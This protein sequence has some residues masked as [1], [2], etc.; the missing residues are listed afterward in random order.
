MNPAQYLDALLTLPTLY[1]AQVSPDGRWAAWTWY[2][3]GPTA[4]VYAAP[5]DGSAAPI[6]LTDT[7][8]DT[9]FVAWA[10]DSRAVLV[11][12]DHEGDERAQLFRVDLDQPG[13]L[14]PL[15]EPTPNYYLRGGQ[16]HP[17]RRWLFYSANVDERGQEIEPAW[18]YRH[19]LQSGERRALAQPEKATWGSPLLNNQ[20]T[21]ILYS[22]QDLHPGGIQIWMVDVEGHEDRE[23]LN[24]GDTAKVFASWL[25]DGRRALVLAEAATHRRVGV[26]DRET[27]GLHWL[28]DDAQRNIEAAFVPRGSAQPI[29]VIVEMRDAR[30]RCSLLDLTS[31][32]EIRLP[33]IA[34]NLT[35]LRQLENDIWVGE[36]YSANQPTDIVRFSLADLRRETFVSLA[37]VWERTSIKQADLIAAQ[38]F[39]WRSVDQ[40]EIQGWLYCAPEP[41]GTIV[42]IHGGPTWLAEDRVNAEIQFYIAQGFNVLA[43]NYRGST[44]FSLAYQE[45]IKRDGWGG[46]EQDDI[47]AGIEALIAAGV[48]ERGKVGVTGTS[49]GG[50]SSWCAI[51]RCPPELVAAAAPICG[52]TDLVIDYQTTR[53][54]L[55]PYSA[56]MMGGSP[57]Q[58]PERYRERSPIHFVSNIKGRLLIV[59]GLRD[60]NVT[61]ENV[62]A[63]SAALQQHGVEYQTLVFE[64][65]GH[66]IAR[67]K[68]RKVLYQR[69]AAFFAEAFEARL[70]ARG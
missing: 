18:I 66:G 44:G 4:D 15:T 65:E 24:A 43:P 40:L 35:P 33:A 37:R 36:Y 27:G 30:S 41:R 69:L 28:I 7:P 8:E 61:P 45:A 26:W 29:A 56:E 1:D 10:P 64:D 34:G 68:N 57:D 53:P 25:P 17:N 50:Y 5:T 42:Y 54:D 6:R 70:E 38:D 47:R 67:P 55:R 51:T 32:T 16:L 21:H 52:M 13:I 9:T 20:G 19:D 31:G 48:A 46:R 23:V 60:P 12:H 3:A 39:R 14:H 62:R 11:E 63:V 22:R 49:Y 58:A 2:R 59:Q